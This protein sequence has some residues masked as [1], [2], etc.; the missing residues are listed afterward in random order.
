MGAGVSLSLSRDGV[1]GESILSSIS[2]L[3]SDPFPWEYDFY[4]VSVPCSREPGF[5]GGFSLPEFQTIEGDSLWVS[6][7]WS[8]NHLSSVVPV[9]KVQVRSVRSNLP[10]R[11]GR[12]SQKGV[13]PFLPQ[14]GDA[15]AGSRPI[16]A[17]YSK[18]GN[19]TEDTI[20]VAANNAD[21]GVVI[22]NGV[23]KADSSAFFPDR[24]EIGI[25]LKFRSISGSA[26]TVF[27]MYSG[28]TKTAKQSGVARFTKR[29]NLDPKSGVGMIPKPGR[30]SPDPF[31]VANGDW[32]KG[33]HVIGNASATVTMCVV[34]TTS[35]TMERHSIPA[36]LQASYQIRSGPF[37][38]VVEARSLSVDGYT[39][40]MRTEM[41]VRTSSGRHDQRVVGLEILALRSGSVSRSV[42]GSLGSSEVVRVLRGSKATTAVLRFADLQGNVQQN[43]VCGAG[44]TAFPCG[45]GQ[46]GA[47]RLCEVGS[48][49]VCG[50]RPTGKAWPWTGSGC[51]RGRANLSGPSFWFFEEKGRGILFVPVY[52][53]GVGLFARKVAMIEEVG[54]PHCPLKLA[55]VFSTELVPFL[56]VL[57]CHCPS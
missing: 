49:S 7:V 51:A 5:S 39:M 32:Y 6:L 50:Q 46:C 45:F 21:Y 20:S 56:T 13:S 2:S 27:G 40:D 52:A 10:D 18:I 43:G 19:V 54:S 11:D 25:R 9:T 44:F 33:S 31:D 37:G 41:D 22:A 4:V 24:S 53:D 55:L 28:D 23:F 3:I 36:D 42:G 17:R 26:I 1:H 30:Y 38:F 16:G 34:A 8:A 14:K 15:D 29:V 57:G 47:F 48:I 12:P 35:T